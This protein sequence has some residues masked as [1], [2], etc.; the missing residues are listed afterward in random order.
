[1]RNLYL[2]LFAFCF[3][4]AVGQEYRLWRNGKLEWV[5]FYERNGVVTPSNLKYNFIYTPYKKEINNTVYSRTIYLTTLDKKSTWINPEFKTDQQLRYNQV[6]FDIAEWGKTELEDYLRSK[7]KLKAWQ[8]KGFKSDLKKI[9]KGIETRVKKFQK[10][11]ES[12]ANLET[13][14]QWE[15]TVKEKLSKVDTTIFPKYDNKLI[16]SGYITAGGSML[17][18]DVGK[19]FGPG[20][21][22][23]FGS[24]AEFKYGGRL[25]I[26]INV[27][28]T[29]VKESYI[30][31]NKV[32]LEKGRSLGI[33]QFGLT[34]GHTFSS[35]KIKFIPYIV[36]SVGS[37][38]E[39]KKDGD[40]SLSLYNAGLGIDAN[41]YMKRNYIKYSGYGGE[42]R[43]GFY[44]AGVRLTRGF[45]GDFENFDNSYQISAYVGVGLESNKIV[46][47]RKK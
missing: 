13:V 47:R 31:N 37:I 43:Q 4:S 20:A 12:G 27:A 28:T 44:R 17:T 35:E 32:F 26:N 15:Q 8:L 34:Y 42:R 9:E 30:I 11:S 24:D 14:E 18:G 45:G 10:E 7:D 36:G 38:Q 40:N 41:F 1:M 16:W 25:G 29:T 19:Y 3:N 39:F 23:N 33:P 22:F 6:I 21:F 5:D 2:L 46:V